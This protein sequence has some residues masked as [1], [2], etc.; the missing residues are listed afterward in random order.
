M[1][2]QISR[3]LLYAV[4]LALVAVFPST[5]F[6]FIGIK[7]FIFRG[8]VTLAAV[9]IV[10]GWALE[11]EPLSLKERFWP[12]LRSPIGIGFMVLTSVL[13]LATAFAYDPVV[14]FW[15]N[16]ERAEGAFQFLHYLLFFV[17]AA[18][19]LTER[20]HWKAI[21]TTSIIASV[22]VA[23]YGVFSAVDSSA[24]IGPYGALQD[25]GTLGRLLGERFQ[26]SLGNA[27]Y[28]TA[29]YL[30]IAGFIVWLWA[31]ASTR[32]RSALYAVPGLLFTGIFF[33]LSGTRG[34]FLG[35][36]AGIFVAALFYAWREP[37]Y[38][39][40]ILGV[41]AVGV[42]AFGGLLALRNNPTVAQLPGARFLQL[43]ITQVTAQTRLWTWGSAL[44]GGLER[45]ILGWGPE[46]F[47]VVFDRHF[48]T[49]HFDPGQNSETWFDRAHN[50]VLDYLVSAGFLGV[51]A[52]IA[53]VILLFVQV[54]RAIRAN[55]L[56]PAQEAVL[57][58]LPVAYL[59]QSLFLF[60]VLPIFMNLALVAALA[61][62]AATWHSSHPDPL[63]H[64]RDH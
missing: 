33:V 35:A 45:P 1:L 16:Y 3:S 13:L 61:Y 60:D 25:A 4:P 38:R 44:K 52:W 19:V 48:D 26:G 53:F 34:A 6:P 28:V 5:F 15:S 54:R 59:V 14:A 50:I 2:Q 58:A 36:V 57:V 41:L 51:L 62:V 20:K 37:R 8:L 31:G 64:V 21:M 39:R 29:Y 11:E 30:F 22:L 18:G 32:L 43:D 17:L 56:R 9:A 7:Y 10:G 46:N 40:W 49:R 24:F 27:A 23:L 47:S 12:V 42:L 63:R 55:T